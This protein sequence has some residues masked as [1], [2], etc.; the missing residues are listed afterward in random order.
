MATV[1]LT[2]KDEHIPILAEAMRY[3]FPIPQIENP[4]Y[5]D[6]VTTPNEPEFIDQYTDGQW[7]KVCII[8]WLKSN[9]KR[10]KDML[11][12]KAVNNPILDDLVS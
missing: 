8:N 12:K 11:D 1:T 2:I 9:V 5:V 6:D 7:G 4:S 3:F 10:Y